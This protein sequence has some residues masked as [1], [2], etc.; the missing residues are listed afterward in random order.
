MHADLLNSRHTNGDLAGLVPLQ[1]F[2]ETDYFLFL[3]GELQRKEQDIWIKWRPW[4]SLYMK[5]ETPRFLA[6]AVRKKDAEKKL[7]ALGVNSIEMLQKELP[8]RAK[9]LAGLFK[10]KTFFSDPL[11]FFNSQTI[12]SR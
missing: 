7:R 9:K 2:V 1:H 5:S 3:R 11:R 8:E 6:E 4:S 12:G 10:S